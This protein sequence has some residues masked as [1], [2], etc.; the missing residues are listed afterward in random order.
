[1]IDIRGFSGNISLTRLVE[2]MN[3][4]GLLNPIVDNILA[5]RFM[6]VICSPDSALRKY[7]QE[8]RM[9]KETG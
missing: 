3:L 8:E 9:L 4:S 1:M 5:D 6:L 2:E 7:S